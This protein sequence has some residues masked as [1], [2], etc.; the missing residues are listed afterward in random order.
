MRRLLRGVL[1]VSSI[2]LALHL[3]LPQIPGLERSAR[4]V[5]E[6]SPYLV[7][8]AFLAELLSLLCYSELEGRSVGNA[9]GL[10]TSMKSR[11]RG[12]LG[13]WFMIRLAVSEDGVSHVLPGGGT[14]MAAV[15]YG[16]LRARGF[17]PGRIGLALAV[18]TV[19]VYGSLGAIFIGSLAYMLVNRDLGTAGLIATLFGLAVTLAAFAGSYAAYRRPRLVHRALN[20]TLLLTSIVFRRGWSEQ[21]RDELSK[22]IVASIGD[23]LR[24]ARR[25]L[26]GDPK[27]AVKLEA[28]AFGYWVFDF[29]CL[30]LVFQALGVPAG[31]LELL[32]AYGIA[33]AAGQLP[34][35]PGGIGIFE[36]VM[37]AT[38]ALLGVGAAAAIPILGY[39]LFNF[40]LPIPL[41]AV[42]YPTLRLGSKRYARGPDA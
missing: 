30:F 19:L 38:L 23:E 25:Q 36:T 13:R 1:Y 35:T 39:R 42:F 21:R 41:T 18:V 2:G 15:T 27:E 20:R 28:L 12:G 22:K 32:V 7:G 8:A 33:T 37:L 17:E 16:A 5:S 4:L 40:W 14:S 31:V 24:T 34:L 26:I 11:R 3:I 6:A 9:A 29:L 10:G